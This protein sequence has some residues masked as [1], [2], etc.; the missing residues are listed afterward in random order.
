MMIADQGI[1]TPVFPMLE[2][3]I[4]E[5]DN[6]KKE[7]EVVIEEYTQQ[8]SKSLVWV[9]YG[10]N[11][12]ISFVQSSCNPNRTRFLFRA[13][14]AMYDGVLYDWLQRYFNNSVFHNLFIH[15]NVQHDFI[16]VTGTLYMHITADVEKLVSDGDN[17]IS[18]A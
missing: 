5:I 17:R 12:N 11:H 7:K 8:I 1:S 4:K 6:L 13:Q 15:L 10:N 14:N 3:I 18:H 9:N 2:A 16:R